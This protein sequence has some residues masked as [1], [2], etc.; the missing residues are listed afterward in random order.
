[1]NGGEV[2]RGSQHLRGGGMAQIMEAEVL[3]PGILQRLL[4]CSAPAVALEGVSTAFLSL[5][6]SCLRAGAY[7]LFTAQ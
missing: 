3:Y 4:P 1:M 7:G 6:R 2:L 5:G